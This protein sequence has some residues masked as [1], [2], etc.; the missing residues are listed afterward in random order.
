MKAHAALTNIAQSGPAAAATSDHAELASGGSVFGETSAQGSA[1]QTWISQ[2]PRMVAQRRAMQAAL[3]PVPHRD[4]NAPEGAAPLQTRFEGAAVQREKPP[5]A[6]AEPRA[7]NPESSSAVVGPASASAEQTSIRAEAVDARSNQ[8]GMPNQLKAGIE[9]L[10]GMDMS[11]VRVHRNSDKPAQLNALAYA[12][13]N[14]IH[15]GPMQEQHLPHEAWH[16]VQQRQGRVRATMQMAGVGV[17]DDVGLEREADLMGARA[18]VTTTP[19]VLDPRSAPEVLVSAVTPCPTTP[20]TPAQGKFVHAKVQTRAGSS[21]QPSGGMA[22]GPVAQRLPIRVVLHGLTHLVKEVG[23]SIFEGEEIDSAGE[24]E[25]GQALVIDDQDI[26]VSRRGMNQEI[27]ENR[28]RDRVGPQSHEWFHVLELNHKDVSSMNVFVRQ[29]MIHPAPLEE[30]VEDYRSQL[31]DDK[32]AGATLD[33]FARVIKLFKENE[34]MSFEE[35]ETMLRT[36]GFKGSIHKELN[37]DL[38]NFV[39]SRKLLVDDLQQAVALASRPLIGDAAAIRDG[40]LLHSLRDEEGCLAAQTRLLATKVALVKKMLNGSIKPLSEKLDREV[41]SLVREYI[42]DRFGEW[43]HAVSD[44]SSGKYKSLEGTMDDILLAVQTFDHFQQ[45][46]NSDLVG[47]T[48][49]TMQSLI[50]EFLECGNPSKASDLLTRIV[51]ENNTY[52]DVW[53]IICPELTT[54]AAQSNDTITELLEKLHQRE[55]AAAKPVK[56]SAV[57]KAV[58]DHPKD[59]TERIIRFGKDAYVKFKLKAHNSGKFDFYTLEYKGKTIQNTIFLTVDLAEVLWQR[60]NGFIQSIDAPK[61]EKSD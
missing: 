47:A 42:E 3:G 26:I 36:A 46:V 44:K 27:H 43:L 24:L 55:E 29:D 32:G 33:K 61:E 13:G 31:Q 51:N 9:S 58:K 23:G 19:E 39:D 8:T 41:A 49:A 52:R 17:N 5:P 25:P 10:S 6:S 48:L 54:L 20:H 7:A 1:L 35:F 18:V 60:I 22:S 34:S 50:S 59:D 11:G 38:I 21:A 28:E 12:Q 16:V 30:Q 45:R 2:S 57:E 56:K 14:Q 4:S 37:Q 53:V 15:L 40:L